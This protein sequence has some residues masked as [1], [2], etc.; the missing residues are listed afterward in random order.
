M[1][2]LSTKA[3]AFTG[4][5]AAFHATLYLISPAI[6]WRNWAI[7][8]SPI[9]G[10]VLGPW[11]GFI[12]ALIGSTIGRV[13][14]PSPFWMF[15]IIAEPLSVMTAGLLTR[16][17]WQP[18]IALY[19]VMLAAYFIS[20]MGQSLPLWP[21]LDTIAAV[22]LVYPAGKLSKNLFSEKVNLLP[23]SL[24]IVSFTTV[25]MDGLTR[26]FLFIPAGLYGILGLSPADT[27]VVFVAGG[28]DSFIEDAL[29]VLITL[30]VGVPILLALRNVLNIKK[31]LS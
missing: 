28:I 27:A 9:E 31:P 16:D 21:M 5:F 7:Y 24:V 13:V 1:K 19:A 14:L 29:V 23:V 25:A 4:V 26:V 18:V 17:K 2:L 20:P 3:V 11:A 30:I 22:C 6:L 15:A 12:A 10:M 8:L